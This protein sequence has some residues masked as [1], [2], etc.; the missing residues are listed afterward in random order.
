MNRVMKGSVSLVVPMAIALTKVAIIAM[1]L[2][3]KSS[4]ET[5]LFIPLLGVEEEEPLDARSSS[6]RAPAFT[7]L[8]IKREKL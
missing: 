1:S 7:F 4:V 2:K 3:M 8:V 5:P 6:S